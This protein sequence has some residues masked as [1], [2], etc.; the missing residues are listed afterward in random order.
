MTHVGSPNQNKD[1]IV[2]VDNYKKEL[3]ENVHASFTA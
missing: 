1:V 3:S 2:I